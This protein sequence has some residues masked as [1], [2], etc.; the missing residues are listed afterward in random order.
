MQRNWLSAHLF[1][2]GDLRFLLLE[3]VLPFLRDTPYR[4]FFIRYGEGGPHIR[5]RLLPGSADIALIQSQLIAAGRVIEGLTIQFIAYEPEI[6]RY[7]DED[8]IAWA[9]E[10]FMCS[11][12]YVLDVLNNKRE[13]DASGALLEA[14]KMNMA[15]ACALDVPAHEMI[16]TCRQFIDQ[17]LPRL[18]DRSKFAAE[19]KQYYTT[20][21]DHRFSHYA[22]LLLPATATLW[23]ALHTGKATPRLQAFMQSN[24]RIFQEYSRLGF[25]DHSMRDITGSFMH[26]GH[27]RLG[28]SNLDEAYIMFFTLKCLENV[29][30][31]GKSER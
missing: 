1:Y 25:D 14:L 28:V 17:W 18:Y 19:Q 11:S 26:M 7:G 8:S 5:L 16:A 12:A 21:L 29:Y 24:R 6:A 15:I 13:W 4:G 31:G 23:E 2:R 3:M 10:Q 20:Q 22:P 30:A 27:N 9:E